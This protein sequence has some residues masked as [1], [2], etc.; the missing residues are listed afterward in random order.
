MPDHDPYTSAMAPA[1]S[2]LHHR[3]IAPF[4]R[5]IT[6]TGYAMEELRTRAAQGPL[7]F[8]TP[9]LGPFEYHYFNWLFLEHRLPLTAY[10]P[11]VHTT[12]WQRWRPYRAQWWQRCRQWL[13]R[14]SIPHPVTS[15]HL[16]QL[17]TQGHAVLLRIRTS[18]LYDDRFW[19]SSRSDPL[20][21]VLTAAGTIAS[22][23]TVVPIQFLWDRR[24]EKSAKSL[25][26]LLFGDRI[27]PGRLRKCLLFLRNYKTRTLVQ[28][29]EPILLTDFLA[30]HPEGDQGARAQLLRDQL[31]HRFFCERKAIAGPRLKP[32]RWMI[33]QTLEDP[34]LQR[35]LYTIAQEQQRSVDDLQLLARRY[36]GE[37]AADVNY[38]YVEIVGKIVR[39]IFR[40]MFD[41]IE[42]DPRSLETLRTAMAEGPIVLV[43][44]HRSHVDYMLLSTFLYQHQLA[45][46]YVAG[47]MNLAFWP[48]GQIARR[49]GAF[50]VRRSFRGNPLY[51]AVFSA[52]L[53][54]LLREGSVV[55]FFIEGG[56]S[57]TGKPLMPRMGILSMMGETLRRGVLTDL[58]YIPVSLTYDQVAEERAYLSEIA[59]DQ[60]KRESF[61]EMIRLGRHL[62]HRY[63]RIY[64]TFGEPVRY[65]TVLQEVVGPSIKATDLAD[66]D[67]RAVTQHLATTLMRQINR[68]IL[69]TPMALT[70]TA[71]LLSQRPAITR[72]EITAAVHG[73]LDYLRWRTVE[74]T[75][76]LERDPEQTI[77][78]VL[79]QLRRQRLLDYHDQFEPIYYLLD[80]RHR[81]ALDLSKNTM[82]H[83]LVTISTIA[84]VL[85]A[86]ARPGA[87]RAVSLA[88]FEEDFRLCQSLFREEFVF[89]THR[90][91]R[92][93]LKRDLNYLVERGMITLRH[94]T[95]L[96]TDPIISGIEVIPQSLDTLQIFANVLRNY[97]TSYHVLLQTA[98]QCAEAPLDV[99]QLCREARAYG[100]HLL[101]LGRLGDPEAISEVTFRNAIRAFTAMGVLTVHEELSRGR[102]IIRVEW[103]ESTTGTIL[104][105]KLQEWR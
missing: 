3:L 41:G 81:P 12:H 105:E 84:T 53:T 1:L 25:F 44:N 35:A 10:A 100:T 5:E 16:Q 64:L 68:G 101:R 99:R 33:E 104:Q 75:K 59:G 29:G 69:V 51:R 34:Q 102:P 2:P 37:I 65:H 95:D 43:P 55:E 46:P 71:L 14:Q 26:D 4:F 21:A 58:R 42:H 24:P 77:D 47:G 39:W 83:Y 79:V 30:R 38:R 32:R 28:C 13:Q 88:A 19:E 22:P 76:R 54:L 61:W 40:L 48:F 93:H 11:N 56:R 85:K 57:R 20:E 60:K 23:C 92:P 45:L 6:I 50:F 91:L 86:S 63:G 97:F 8:V 52:Y 87:S 66:H 74:C 73:L 72:Q 96:A 62:R 90:E 27:T 17:I 9:L 67:H 18:R 36:V 15:G 98:V 7:I 31:L 89:A 82:I 70:A 94:E 78:E 49:C 80:H 103:T